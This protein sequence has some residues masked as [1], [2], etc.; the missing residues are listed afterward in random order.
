MAKHMR[1]KSESLLEFFESCG[2]DYYDIGEY[3]FN[4]FLNEAQK[5]EIL[6]TILNNCNML[7]FFDNREEV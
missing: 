5:T 4:H 2:F 3:V 7:K 1:Y 6:E